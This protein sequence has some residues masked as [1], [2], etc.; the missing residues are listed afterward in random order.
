MRERKT[1]PGLDGRKMSK[2]YKNEIPLFLK[3]EELHKLI[4]KIKTD[5]RSAEEPK[6]TENCLIFEIFKHFASKK[7]IQDLRDC[8]TR[9]IAWGEAKDILFEKLGK[10]FED[11]KKI[12][13]YYIRQPLELEKI[14]KRGSEKARS[15]AKFFLKEVKESLGL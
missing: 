14:L 15:V 7:E 5:S 8:Y 3:S 4:R 2:S 11:K 10:Y 12:Y 1:L 13:D 6:D 9:G